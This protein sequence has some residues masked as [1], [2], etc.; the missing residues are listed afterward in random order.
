VIK[1]SANSVFKVCINWKIIRNH[2]R[3]LP[4]NCFWRVKNYLLVML[5]RIILRIGCKNIQAII[6]D[7]GVIISKKFKIIKVKIFWNKDIQI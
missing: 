3:I 2:L 6:R 5:K 1:K 4:N 7:L